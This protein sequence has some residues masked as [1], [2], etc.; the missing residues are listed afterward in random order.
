MAVIKVWA[1]RARAVELESGGG[2]LAL[3]PIEGGWWRAGAADLPAG[4]D[5]AFR[6]DG[7]GPFPDPRSPW[8]PSGVNGPSR[9]LD[10][11]RFAWRDSGWQP[12]HFASGIVYELHVGTFTPEGTFLS[13]SPVSIT[14]PALA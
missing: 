10:H 2:A 5:Y 13:R 1:P 12:P 4:T 7:K 11:A 3:E 14:W 6:V 9:A 8:Q